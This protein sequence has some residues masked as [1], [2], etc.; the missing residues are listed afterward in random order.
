MIIITVTQRL[1]M[2]HT[3]AETAP[4]FNGIPVCC[5]IKS[6]G[7]TF[8]DSVRLSRTMFCERRPVV[9]TILMKQQLFASLPLG[10]FTVWQ[11]PRLPLGQS[12]IMHLVILTMV[13]LMAS[14][15][16]SKGLLRLGLPQSFS[17]YVP[18]SVFPCFISVGQKTST[19]P[20]AL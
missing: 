7:L 15:R 5:T 3:V 8:K 6:F 12:P 11:R 1:S 16:D 9:A 20:R 4:D 10:L 2:L 18:Q 13:L 14:V 19:T 17:P